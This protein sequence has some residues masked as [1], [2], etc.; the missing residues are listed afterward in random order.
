MVSSKYVTREIYRQEWEVYW[1]KITFSNLLQSWEYGQAKSSSQGWVPLRYAIEN[2]DGEVVA[3]AQILTKTL[4]FFGGV[5]RLNRGPLLF[6]EF[7][8]PEY[9]NYLEVLQSI[10]ELKQKK[11]WWLFFI[12]PEIAR[13]IV[14]KSKLD[15]LGLRLRNTSRWGSSV[16]NLKC[17]LD[18]IV[19]NLN[20]KW[21]N[22][23]RK[24]QK[25]DLEVRKIVM[26]DPE[27]E[28]AMYMYKKMQKEKNFSGT[29]VD[30]LRNLGTCKGSVWD[31]NIYIGE[32]DFPSGK[33]IVGMVITVRHN[34]TST[35]LVGCSSHEGRKLSVNYIL[36]FQAISDAKKFGCLNF[37][38]GGLNENT[39]KGVAHFKRGI[40]GKEYELLGELIP[41]VLLLS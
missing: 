37:D 2:I 7:D 8:D 32:L 11:R 18:D 31:F 23:L 27:F 26:S 20:G 15:A 16:V 41:R 10:L 40:S 28:R 1:G 34:K 13:N 33:E 5:A 36:L 35:Y 29:P 39:P 30:L 21:R 24:A 17:N 14:D 9:E 4:P 6:T 25:S 38:L 12:A 19:K 3:I 22:L